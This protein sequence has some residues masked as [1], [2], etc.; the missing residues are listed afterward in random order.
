MFYE[1]S[2]IVD[3]SQVTE[4]SILNGFDVRASQSEHLFFK[5]FLSIVITHSKQ[6]N[7]QIYQQRSFAEVSNGDG[8]PMVKIS[9]L[10]LFIS[11]FHGTWM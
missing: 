3:R 5:T 7:L 2:F 8:F 11:L 1:F 6:I 10:S 4:V 9:F